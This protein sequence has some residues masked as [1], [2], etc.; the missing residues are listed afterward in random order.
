LGRE[1]CIQGKLEGSQD[2]LDVLGIGPSVGNRVANELKEAASANRD[3]GTHAFVVAN[4][5]AN[6]QKGNWK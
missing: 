2:R 4:K 5:I 3:N 6:W 1:N